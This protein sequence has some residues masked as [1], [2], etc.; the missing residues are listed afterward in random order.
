MQVMSS[1][2]RSE[3]GSRVVLA[4]CVLAI[5][6]GVVLVAQTSRT[7][8]E[9]VSVEDVAM[10][11]DGRTVW[12]TVYTNTCGEPDRLVIEETSSEVV[13]T[14]LIRQR[15]GECVGLSH[16][17]RPLHP[18]PFLP[19]R[20]RMTVASWSCSPG[21]APPSRKAKRASSSASSTRNASS[22]SSKTA[23]GTGSSVGSPL[24]T[25]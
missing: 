24:P 23:R 10:D 22:R 19:W 25:G 18:N 15:S 7:T 21:A 11:G 3:F 13:V 1:H 9:Q 6:V 20:T 14:A 8:T 12:A 2:T 5:S 16:S 17:T 4:A